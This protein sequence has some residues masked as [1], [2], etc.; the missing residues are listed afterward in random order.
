MDEIWNSLF[1]LAFGSRTEPLK[2][3]S[4]TLPHADQMGAY[5]TRS[6]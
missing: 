3:V 5:A 1:H 6:T 4:F 2:L